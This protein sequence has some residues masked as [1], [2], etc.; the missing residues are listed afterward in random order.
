MLGCSSTHKGQVDFSLFGH[1]DL[2]P[3][4]D[5]M[6]R[7]MS[8]HFKAEIEQLVQQCEL[9]LSDIYLLD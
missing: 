9:P 4:Q 6:N 7:L 5:A 3:D 8:V 1:P 2:F